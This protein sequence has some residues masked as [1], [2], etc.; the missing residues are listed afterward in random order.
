MRANI[1]SGCRECNL[2][3]NAYSLVVCGGVIVRRKLVKPW[4]TII[5]SLIVALWSVSSHA[6]CGVNN[7]NADPGILTVNLADVTDY[8]S[9]T[10]ALTITAAEIE[11]ATNFGMKVGDD[12]YLQCTDLSSGI[13]IQ[14]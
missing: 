1:F 12:I 8:N 7:M 5:P 13:I 2:E 6:I 3:I 9:T 11:A 4:H 10:D 14:Q